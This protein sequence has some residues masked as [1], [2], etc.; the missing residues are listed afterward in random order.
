MGIFERLFGKHQ[1]SRTHPTGELHIERMDAFRVE[2]EI[3]LTTTAVA[4]QISDAFE[5]EPGLKRWMVSIDVLSFYFHYMNRRAFSTRG[6]DFRAALQDTV[7]ISGIEKLFDASIDTSKTTPGFDKE[8]FKRQ[9][10]GDALDVINENEL[11]FA[12]HKEM[13]TDNLIASDTVLGRY[14]AGLMSTIGESNTHPLR[15]LV[16]TTTL[17]ALTQSNIIKNIDNA[18]LRS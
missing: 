14:A 6:A 4:Q 18:R 9:T 16:A 8:S 12:N 3:L 5:V 15:I 17:D 7:C 1:T 13:F 11:G 10:V 2:S